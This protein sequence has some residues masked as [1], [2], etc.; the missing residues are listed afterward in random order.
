MELLHRTAATYPQSNC[1]PFFVS[2]GKTQSVVDITTT[3]FN[4]HKLINLSE[5]CFQGHEAE[6][7]VL[8]PHPFDP[9]IILSAGHDGNV[10]IWDLQ[11][12]TNTQHYFNMVHSHM[13]KSEH[14]ASMM[15][16]PYSIE[17]PS[18]IHMTKK[19]ADNMVTRQSQLRHI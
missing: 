17:R 10:F 15:N 14:G 12:G 11:R 7:F 2:L 16:K 5:H 4:L 6:V 18:M 1:A 3:S 9:R 13:A 8:E 19:A